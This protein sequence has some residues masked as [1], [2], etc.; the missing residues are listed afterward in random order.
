MT[1]I[2]VQASLAENFSGVILAPGDAGY[3]GARKVHNGLIDKRPALIASCRN[4]ADVVAAVIAAR[5]ADL[6]ISVRGGGHNVAGKAVTEGGLMI[7]FSSMKGIHV[8]PVPRTVRAQAGVTVRELDRAT[9]HLRARDAQRRGLEHRHR[10]A[11]ARRRTHLADGP[12]RDGD[13]Q[14]RSPPRWCSPR[15]TS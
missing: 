1:T 14:S 9:R 6:E 2:D 15:A 8:D 7:D 10:G 5:E 3:D 4:T 12:L 13:R 11:H